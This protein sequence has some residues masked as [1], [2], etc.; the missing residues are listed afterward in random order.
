MVETSF[1]FVL[2]FRVFEFSIKVF[3]ETAAPLLTEST[4]SGSDGVLELG[5][6]EV[7]KDAVSE[8][9]WTVG[10]SRPLLSDCFCSSRFETWAE[11][12]CTASIVSSIEVLSAF[13]L[14]FRS[15]SEAEATPTDL[16]WSVTCFI[17]CE[18]ELTLDSSCWTVCSINRSVCSISVALTPSS[19]SLTGIP[20]LS[21]V[22]KTSA[23][24]AILALCL[25]V[26]INMK[27]KAK[28]TE[29]P[30]TA[31]LETPIFPE[32]DRLVRPE[33]A[34]PMAQISN[35]NADYKTT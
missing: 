22:T 3:D 25:P 34:H 5:L 7:M 24:F 32:L 20:Y 9:G 14:S 12:C 28:R 2:F 1:C 10:D 33:L 17:C 27:A 13:T 21:T 35:R 23:E 30:A 16:R 19:S 26:A 29:A 6:V 15:E 31:L 18:R 8:S 11:R 4:G